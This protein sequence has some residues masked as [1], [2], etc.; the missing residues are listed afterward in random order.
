MNNSP[1][2]HQTNS[3]SRFRSRQ[4]VAVRA[5]ADAVLINMALVAALISR[6]VYVTAFELPAVRNVPTFWEY[7]SAYAVSFWLFTPLALAILYAHGVYTAGRSYRRRDKVFLIGR[8]IAIAYL[9]FGFGSYFLAGA[10][11]FP[12]GA[13]VLAWVLTNVVLIG[14]RVWTWLWLFWAGYSVSSVPADIADRKVSKVLV[15]GGAGYI[16]SEV[17]RLLLD[18][19]Y[20][21]RV[22]DRLI[23][24]IKPI[25]QLVNHPN[26]E[27]VKEDFR[28]VDQVV[29]AMQGVD[30][31]VH[32]GAIVG[33]P[34]C[35]LDE[36][37]TIQINLTATRMIAEVAK[38]VGV[39]RFIFASTCSVYGASD[40]LLDERSVLR[41]VSLYAKSK[42][43]SEQVLRSMADERFAPIILR[44][45]TIYGLSGRTRFDLVANLMTAT[46]MFEGKITVRGGDQ[47]RPFVH[48]TDAA[49]AAVK[50]VEAPLAVVRNHAFNVGSD[51]QNCT[52]RGLA[53]IVAAQV[54]GATIV[55]E[56]VDSDRRNYRVSFA[57]IRRA[58]D[59]RPEWSLPL[60]INQI[61]DAVRNGTVSNYRD[62]TFSN[63]RFLSEEGLLQLGKEQRD[64]EQELLRG[65]A[66]D[67][68]RLDEYAGS[69]GA[70]FASDVKS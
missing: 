59:F 52:L 51:E 14:A 16:G 32:L 62:P 13:L 8:A 68:A 53:E 15:I 20:T 25:E 33:D 39:N 57:A 49:R 29:E 44:F 60:G 18:R 5:L 50:C 64:W 6:Y 41:P 61:V 30:A 66:E 65:A 67:T 42:I 4:G 43:A 2:N 47:W 27:I 28:K 7:V 69:G 21:V 1:N 56:A 46:A 36:A 9:A 10:F 58:I 31:V 23:Y 38:G 11:Y 45:G 3:R 22:L 48:V 35:A 54:P 19:G 63:V 24:G 37:L 40:E 12:R 34:A 26:L 55:D 17:V 70:L